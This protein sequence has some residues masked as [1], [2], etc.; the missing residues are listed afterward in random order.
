[1][2]LC[3]H[4]YKFGGRRD[5]DRICFILS[6]HLPNSVNFSVPN[7]IMYLMFIICQAMTHRCFDKFLYSIMPYLHNCFSL[8][9]F[10][11]C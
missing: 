8:N 3:A 4:E 2:S 5:D 11:S 1:M 7:S 6:V 10:F 9:Q